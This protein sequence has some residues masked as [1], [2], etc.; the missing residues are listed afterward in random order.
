R[1]ARITVAGKWKYDF[2]FEVKRELEGRVKLSEAIRNAIKK[3][4]VSSKIVSQLA[5]SIAKNPEILS[6]LIPMELEYDVLKEAEGFLSREL[7]IQVIVDR[8][9]E[10]ISPK[11]GL[12]LPG[13]PAIYIE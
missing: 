10:S 13:K 1:M 8:E 11:R 6:M 12:A 4:N 9:E 2:A 5:Q 3:M 7:G